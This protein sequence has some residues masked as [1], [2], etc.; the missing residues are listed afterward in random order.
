MLIHPEERIDP[1]D[2]DESRQTKAMLDHAAGRFNREG[3]IEPGNRG[4]VICMSHTPRPTEKARAP[5]AVFQRACF[6]KKP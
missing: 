4:P 3:R 5:E 6:G 2:S 1:R